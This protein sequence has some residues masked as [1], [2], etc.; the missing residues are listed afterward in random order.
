MTRAPQVHTFGALIPFR[1]PD[2]EMLF[3]NHGWH[4]IEKPFLAAKLVERVNDVL[5][6]P[7]SSQGDDHF[8]TRIKSK[9]SVA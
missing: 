3:L 5:H 7:E 2:G 8:D 4:F 9:R 1:Y 6:T